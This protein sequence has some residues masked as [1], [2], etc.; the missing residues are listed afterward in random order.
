M[1]E[2]SREFLEFELCALSYPEKDKSKLLNL[3]LHYAIVKKIITSGGKNKVSNKLLEPIKKR[4]HIYI[5]IELIM[6]DHDT[7]NKYIKSFMMT[8][9]KQPYCR[10]GEDFFLET[11][12]KKFDYMTFSI[13]CTITAVQGK[14]AEWKTISKE[15]MRAGMLGYKSKRIMETENRSNKFN[16]DFQIRTRVERLRGIE[17]ISHITV[18]KYSYY[19][20]FLAQNKL[21]KLAKNRYLGKVK[22]EVENKNVQQKFNEKI[23]AEKAKIILIKPKKIKAVVNNL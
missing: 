2:L 14:R 10:I 8:Y 5:D 15:R 1:K 18:F 13:L 12:Q 21:E 20:T 9:G 17:I 4:L 3:I 11:I 7:M 23:R 22:H 6:K 19:S 16:S